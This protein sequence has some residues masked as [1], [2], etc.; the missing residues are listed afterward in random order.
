MI[1]KD[2]FSNIGP[3]NETVEGFVILIFA[4]NITTVT[5]KIS[6]K[7]HKSEIK[8]ATL[9]D[10]SLSIDIIVILRPKAEESF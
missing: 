2:V 9:K 1:S 6:A 4:G 8:K 7:C 5:Q 3:K 10:L